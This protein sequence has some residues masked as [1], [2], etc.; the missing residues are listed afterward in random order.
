M[1]GISGPAYQWIEGFLTNRLQ[2][3]KI[4]NSIS[5]PAVVLSG[6][7]QGTVLG[8]LLFLCF[9]ADLPAVVESSTLSIYAD[10]TKLYKAIYNVEDCHRLQSDLNN[11]YN[12]AKIWQMELNPD[13]TK[14]LT[15]GSS[16]GYNYMLNE[17][18]IDK[19]QYINDVGVIVQ[20]NLKFSKHCSNVV[21]KAYFVIRKIFTTF[22]HH[23][24][25]FYMKMY[26][27]YVRPILEYASQVW[28]PLLK[29]NIDKIENV[30][31]YFTRRVLND[32]N[33]NY[34]Q[35]LEFSNLDNLEQRRLK[36]DLVLFYK[37]IN[38]IT[39]INLVG[40]FRIVNTQRGHV[41]HLFK[42]YCRTEKR[43]LFWI[44]RLVDN[45]NGLNQNIISSNSVTSFNKRIKFVI[46]TCRGSMSC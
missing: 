10:D 33:L 43:K 2:R 45:W 44:N 3:V 11:V 15:I 27:C 16:W 29:G 17:K 37:M 42:Y 36:S 12:W 34:C 6:V 24:Y 19:V 39:C 30:Q 41:C 21:K 4:N 14:V 20:S 26:I 46:L 32:R 25:K 35:R 28:S 9:S 5:E 18:V 1:Y 13:K 7:P 40:S 31:R 22:K 8:P 38:G 23:D